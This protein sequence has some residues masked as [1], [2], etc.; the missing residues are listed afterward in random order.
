MPVAILSN[1]FLL[2]NKEKYAFCFKKA[3]GL[4]FKQFIYYYVF[5]LY[6]KPLIGQVAGNIL[7]IF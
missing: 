2:E 5:H 1:S 3:Y 6:K 7:S 4:S